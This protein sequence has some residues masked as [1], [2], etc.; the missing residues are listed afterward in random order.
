MRLLQQLKSKKKKQQIV[1]KQRRR[2][3]IKIKF[4]NACNMY[5]LFLVLNGVMRRP[6]GGR[7]F[8]DGRDF[9]SAINYEDLP[10]LLLCIIKTNKKINYKEKL[11]GRLEWSRL[12]GIQKRKTPDDGAYYF[13]DLRFC[14]QT[15][16]T[17]LWTR[18]YRRGTAYREEEE[19]RLENSPSVH[20]ITIYFIKT[21]IFVWVAF[22]NILNITRKG[23]TTDH[24]YTNCRDRT[25][26]Q[27][28]KTVV[29]IQ[30]VY[31]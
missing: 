6:R 10:S 11:R 14:K 7:F 30:T 8:N 23:T 22:L 29:V 13:L 2:K 3:V 5:L 18:A 12:V 31:R 4:N 21:N 19:N 28:F 15:N 27:Y 16:P 9:Y 17:S 25:K 24:T 20:N 1:V 26:T